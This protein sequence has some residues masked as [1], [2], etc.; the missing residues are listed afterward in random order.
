MR[1]FENAVREQ[2]N[3]NSLKIYEKLYGEP[4]NR[5][6]ECTEVI[7]RQAEFLPAQFY[8]DSNRE[9]LLQRESN[10]SEFIESDLNGPSSSGFSKSINKNSPLQNQNFFSAV[11]S[12]LNLEDL[13]GHEIHEKPRIECETRPETLCPEIICSPQSSDKNK[14]QNS[15]HSESRAANRPFECSTPNAPNTFSSTSPGTG[16]VALQMQKILSKESTIRTANRAGQKRK[17]KRQNVLKVGRLRMPMRQLGLF[18]WTLAD[19]KSHEKFALLLRENS[20]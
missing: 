17:A 9:Q 4:E 7:R 12:S 18:E 2:E 13:R 15:F 14:G 20:P 8:R 19:P 16:K 1:P 10:H 6:S 3:S 11:N 5:N